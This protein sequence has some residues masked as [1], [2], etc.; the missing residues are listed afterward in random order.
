MRPMSDLSDRFD[1]GRAV[2]A[3]SFGVDRKELLPAM[4]HRV[5]SV[6][7]EEAILAAGGPAWNDPG[8]PD[9]DRSIA[10]LT[11][12]ICE[13]VLGERLVAHLERAVRNGVDQ[14]AIE[15]LL[16]LLAIYVGQERTSVAAEEVEKFFRG[17][18]GRGDEQ[19]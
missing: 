7:A 4:T 12:L 17:R 3:E 11:A 16:V 13:G 19:R 15:V 8:L 14:H 6:Y 2:F 5:G 1:R 18:A 9:R 10:V